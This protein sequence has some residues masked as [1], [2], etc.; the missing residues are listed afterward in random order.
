MN[1]VKRAERM[2]SYA[3]RTQEE[4]QRLES[5]GEYLFTY[6]KDAG[7]MSPERTKDLLPYAVRMA[8]KQQDENKY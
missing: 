3:E 7:R 5:I 4:A 8:I 1:K 2:R 6:D